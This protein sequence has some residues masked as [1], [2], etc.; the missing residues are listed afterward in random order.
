MNQSTETVEGVPPGIRRARLAFLRDFESLLVSRKTRG[1][2]VCYHLDTLVAIT[3]DYLSMIRE[4]NA[5]NI[6]DFESHIF[7]VEPGCDKTERDALE[8]IEIN[9]D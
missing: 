4:L 8:E 9:P 7:K 1:K 2:Y 5:K 6:P 3:K